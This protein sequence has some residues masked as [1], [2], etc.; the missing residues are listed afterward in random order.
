MEFKR[1]GNTGL[2]VSRMCLGTG[3]FGAKTD[4]AEAGRMI[5]RA[6]EAGV[7]FLDTADIY[8][9]GGAS[10]SSEE[11]LGRLLKGR[12]ERFVVSTKAGHKIGPSAW[13]QGTSRKHLL[14]AIDASL[15][16]LNTDYIDIYSVH[17]D[18]LSTPIDETVEAMD[19]IV[20]SGKARYIGV[21]NFLTYRLAKSLGRQEALKLAR[22]VSVQP[23]YS[24]LFREVEREL[25]PLA[26][27]ENVA[28]FSYN[29][30]AGGL[31]SGRYK[32]EETPDSGRF[33]A[34]SMYSARY[35]REKEFETVKK[36]STVAESVGKPIATVS[37]AWI[38]ANPTITS[39][40]LGASNTDQLGDTIAA[41]DASLDPEIK[42]KLDDL[43]VE[44]RRGDAG[45]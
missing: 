15:Q 8:P 29:P 9:P 14:D 20:R 4:E 35:W 11:I 16:R 42:Q 39:V 33:A 21:S 37:I 17:M 27:E 7:N 1:F 31:L 18:D 26:Q 23:R 30:L 41:V 44:Y 28:V 34:G 19:T 25:F 10:G 2:T 36:V 43:S 5:D 6:E 13:D 32:F 45:K 3:T 22:Y 40:I 24:L 38:L 12:R